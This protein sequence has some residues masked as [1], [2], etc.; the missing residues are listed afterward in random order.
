MALTPA[1]AFVLLATPRVWQGGQQRQFWE[2]GPEAT[3][4]FPCCHSVLSLLQAVFLSF[5]L[6]ASQQQAHE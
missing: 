6:L 4:D 3:G 1:F 2:V 5:S